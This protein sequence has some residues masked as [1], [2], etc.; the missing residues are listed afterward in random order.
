MDA[1]V[2]SVYDSLKESISFFSLVPTLQRG[3]PDLTALA[4]SYAALQRRDRRFHAERGN[5][6]GLDAPASYIT[7][8]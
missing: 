2:K 7:N 4:V 1:Y 3:N 8:R 6:K 5:E